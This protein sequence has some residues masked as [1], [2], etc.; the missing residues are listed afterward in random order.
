MGGTSTLKAD[1]RLIAASNRELAR[2]VEAGR[3]REDLYY[4]LN[5]FSVHL[6][7]LRE[8]GEDVLLLAD[9][10]VSELG[11]RMAK[12]EIGLSRDA[13]EALLSH[14][15]P[16]NIRELQNAVERALIISDGGLLSAAQLGIVPR[17]E[18]PQMPEDRLAD[19]MIASS[20]LPEWEKRMVMDVL[21]KTKGN[22]SK[23]AKLLGLTRSQLYTRLKR[24]G[25]EA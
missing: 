24:F 12:G 18:R 23:A 15:W 5:V 21:Q 16:G 3:F 13:S 6:P 2:E 8:R 1:V 11:A 25:L 17:R 19:P 14:T 10:F 20:T 7:P 4:R 9:H 22:K